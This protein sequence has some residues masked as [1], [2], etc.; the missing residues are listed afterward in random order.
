MKGKLYHNDSWPSDA[1][2]SES[3]VLSTENIFKK[4]NML[5]SVIYNQAK[6]YLYLVTFL[7]SMNKKLL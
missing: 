3:D 2:S 4:I 5:N 1:L 6:A 7:M